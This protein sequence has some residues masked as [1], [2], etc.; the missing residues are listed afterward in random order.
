MERGEIKFN[1]Y[2]NYVGGNLP[3]VINEIEK[4]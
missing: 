1:C 2:Y 3:P 4:W